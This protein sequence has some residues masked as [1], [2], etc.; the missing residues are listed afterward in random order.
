MS[1]VSFLPQA[2]GSMPQQSAVPDI[3][4]WLFFI[5]LAILIISYSLH[6]VEWCIFKLQI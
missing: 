6:L 5:W 3:F 4:F 1:K 2:A